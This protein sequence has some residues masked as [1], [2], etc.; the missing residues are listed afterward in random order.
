MNDKKGLIEIWGDH[1]ELKSMVLSMILCSITSL[2]GYFLAFNMS[3]T[4]QLFLGILG[5]ALG[6]GLSVFYIKPKRIIEVEK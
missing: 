5:A 1:V 3:S 2:G 6:F 4:L